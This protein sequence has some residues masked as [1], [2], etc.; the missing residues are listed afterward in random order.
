MAKIEGALG[1]QHTYHEEELN[2]ITNLFNN[3]LEGDEYVGE[4]LPMKGVDLFHC[5]SDG[6]MMI[7]LL[8]QIDQDCVDMRAVNKGT[9]L[10][11]YKVREN[12]NLA[13][14]SAKGKIKLVGI[15]ASAFLE[16]KP[17]LVLGVSW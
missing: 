13:L 16:K 4:R 12:I 17:H 7:R 2:V 6:M 14:T 3:L 8:N 5:M 11:I 10:N 15:E 1:S 9:N